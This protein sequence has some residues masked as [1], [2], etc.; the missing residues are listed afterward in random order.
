MLQKLFSVFDYACY[1]YDIPWLSSTLSI[2]TLAPVWSTPDTDNAQVSMDEDIA[3][4][5]SVY[6]LLASDEDGD[7]VSYSIE[8]QTP[9][10]AFVLAGA[11]INA[12]ATP[13]DADAEGATTSYTLTLRLVFVPV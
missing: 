3:S 9:A 11:Q 4:G 1:H 13:F 2:P 8:S 5:G 10:N 12:G 6:T 7:T